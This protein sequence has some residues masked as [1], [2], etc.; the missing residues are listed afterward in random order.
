MAFYKSQKP[1]DRIVGHFSLV[2]PFFNTWKTDTCFSSGPK[3]AQV[4][5]DV[6]SNKGAQ[7]FGHGA[8]LPGSPPP[9]AP[10]FPVIDTPQVCGPRILV[11]EWSK[12]PYT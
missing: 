8:S 10:H 2:F 6:L 5:L 7:V 4:S 3:E 11:G 9:P 12:T 1:V